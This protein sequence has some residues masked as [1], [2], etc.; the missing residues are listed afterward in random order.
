MNKD[1]IGAQREG[2]GKFTAGVDGDGALK[3]FIQ[4][5]EGSMLFVMEMAIYKMQ[6]A[7]RIDPKRENANIPPV[8]Q[9]QVL[10]IGAKSELVGRIL[11]T[12]NQLFNKEF[13]SD[14]ICKEA[15]A[16]S[17]EALMNVV[18]MQE[19]AIEFELAERNAV[20]AYN[21]RH[22]M[23][24]EFILPS[25]SGVEIFSKEFFQKAD[26]V[27][28]IICDLIKLFYPEVVKKKGNKKGGDNKDTI[29]E[30]LREHLLLEY[31]ADD[32]FVKFIDKALLFLK[33]IRNVRNC[34]EHRHAKGKE[35]G[36]VLNNFTLLPEGKIY[37]PTIEINFRST[38]QPQ[39]F[40]STFLFDAVNSM[41]NVF[42]EMMVHLCSKSARSSWDRALFVGVEFI[43]E[44][45]RRNKHVKYG[46]SIHLTEE[47]M[48]VI[49]QL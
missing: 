9:Q 48:S 5:H 33:M 16:L 37:A 19:I 47:L 27:E 28:Q 20:E 14:H 39:I 38:K 32:S 23:N 1:P 45:A 30:L 15:K 44:D 21:M 31:A 26:H 22:E 36:V 34:L 11:L 49:K 13:L 4:I 41:V 7:D 10:S 2:G 6:M 25:V 3:E 18:A 35:L 40:L 46:Y 43:P 8:V 17:F 12:A 24:A 29:F 42:E